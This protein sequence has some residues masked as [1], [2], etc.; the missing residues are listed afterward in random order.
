MKDNMDIIKMLQERYSDYKTKVYKSECGEIFEI[1]N[2]N[3]EENI[4]IKLENNQMIIFYFSYQHAHFNNDIKG[5]FE[6][7]DQFISDS[8]AAIEF[9][10]DGK[11]LFGGGISLA[12]VNVLSADELAERFGFKRKM[13]INC[14]FKVRSWSGRDDLDAYIVREKRKIICKVL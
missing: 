2:P 13:L 5:L 4:Q 6:Y 10:N 14:C 8:L 9:F 11:N 7:I 1:I 12:E 3:K